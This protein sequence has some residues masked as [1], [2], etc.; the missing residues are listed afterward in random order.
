MA[1]LYQVALYGAKK[2]KWALVRWRK[3]IATIVKVFRTAEEA[4]E[5][6]EKAYEAQGVDL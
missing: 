5:A 3:G 1:D 6:W 2:N 4:D